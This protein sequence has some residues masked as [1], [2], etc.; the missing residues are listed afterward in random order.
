MF[1][2]SRFALSHNEIT[3]EYT[4]DAAESV[5]CPLCN[6]GLKYRNKKKRGSIDMAGSVTLFLL[7]RFRRRICGK[8][9]TEVPNVI[10]PFKH[11]DSATI[12]AVLHGDEEADTCAADDS[13]IRRW[14]KTFAEAKPDIEQ[15]LAS[16]LAKETDGSPSF[17]SG[18][19][20]LLGIWSL[21]KHWLAFVMALLINRGHALCTRFAFCP[22]H[23]VGIVRPEGT[24]VENGGMDNDKHFENSS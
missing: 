1:I 22:R 5:S 8:L 13:T 2:V 3:G 16:E 12:Q 24:G 6:G 23:L 4:V 15:R 17:G 21:H 10:Q 20:I 19:S 11:Y 9:H 14:V 7:R 18:A